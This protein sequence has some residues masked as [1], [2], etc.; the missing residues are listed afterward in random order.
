[1]RFG[2]RCA[3]A[4][5]LR[6]LAAALLAGT[7][8]GA[9]D[10]PF[11]AIKQDERPFSIFGLLDARADTQWVRVMPLRQTLLTDPAPIDAVVTLENLTSGR[12][13]TLRDSLFRFMDQRVDSAGYVHLFWTTARIDQG[14]RYRLKVARGDGASTVALVE[15]PDPQIT[16]LYEGGAV[17]TH[18]N[19]SRLQ[20]RAERVLFADLTRTWWD[21]GSNKPAPE[22]TRQKLRPTA[23][24]GAQDIFVLADTIRPAGSPLR[25]KG[26]LELRLGVAPADWPYAPGLSDETVALPDGLPTT[27]ENGLGFVGGVVRWSLPIQTCWAIEARP[28]GQRN[29]TTV[30]SGTSAS[31][32]GRTVP[33]PC[34]VPGEIPLLRLT[35]RFAGGGAVLLQWKSGYDGTY[36]FEGIEPGADLVLE[37]NVTSRNPPPAMHLPR[38]SPGERF[39]VP[40]VSVAI[41]C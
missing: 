4:G 35:Q 6:G 39:V 24:P 7:A 27:V 38:L 25:D 31:I 19:P 1:M 8:A 41:G 30:L 40:D 9:C 36:H 29:C 21:T 11:Q 26:R 18:A 12:T 28:S 34:S 32:R 17:L 5:A 13:V 37:L 16:V 14:A 20:V 15:V 3:R 22:T 23:E 33:E 2:G 10:G